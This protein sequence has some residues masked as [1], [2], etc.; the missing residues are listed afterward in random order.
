MP[1]EI[2][3]VLPGLFDLPAAQC[4]TELLVR[5]LPH[6]NRILRFA[7]ARANRAFSIDAML[8]EV[9]QLETFAAEMP[10]CLPLAQAQVPADGENPERLLVFQAVHLQPD[11][12][13]A[14]IHPIPRNPENLADIGNIIN[15]LKELFKA[16]CDIRAISDELFLMRL[17]ECDAPQ[18]YP[19]ILSVL[20][21]TANPYLSQS[22]RNLA[23]YKLLNEMQ[24]FM[25]QHSVNQA[26]M[27]RGLAAVNSLWL[28]GAGAL[29]GSFERR[30]DWY[31]DDRLLSRFANS[32][33]LAVATIEE[34][35]D[36]DPRDD[37]VAVDLRLLEWL[38]TGADDNL[39]QILIDIDGKLIKPLLEK[40]KSARSP[41]RL[42]A[43]YQF[44]YELTPTSG[45]RFW[46]RSRSLAEYSPVA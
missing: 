6:L 11:L 34:I 5:G 45:I 27:R 30:L 32:L 1:G 41:L 37:I 38:K 4:R 36:S 46:R 17:N 35:A 10:P 25:H 19:H 14:I 29:P 26:R 44:D 39:E 12:R 40:A 31:G 16:D 21:K 15:D 13:N 8:R 9:L 24:M 3:I 42:R 22:R 33:G 43:A 20:G 18:F 7:D 28:W 23:W 2:Q